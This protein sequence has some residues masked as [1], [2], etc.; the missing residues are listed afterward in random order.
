MKVLLT[1]PFYSYRGS[2]PNLPDIALGY[3]ASAVEDISMVKIIDWNN[4]Q[5]IET[6][7]REI[8]A[9]MPDI[10][11]IKC[12]TVN[13]RAVKMTVSLLKRL[14]PQAVIILG[15]PHPT[16]SIPSDIREEFPETDLVILGEAENI[17]RRI[18]LM[19]KEDR[20]KNLVA[21]LKG[22]PGTIAPEFGIMNDEINIIDNLNTLLMPRWDLLD[23]RTYR[24]S[25]VSRRFS[26][27]PLAPVMATRGCPTGCKFCSVERI[28][29]K[30]IRKREA[31][32][33]FNEMDLL[34]HKYGV[35]QFMFTDNSF[36]ADIE[37]VQRLSELIR[38]NS[39]EI[40]YNMI[41]GPGFTRLYSSRDM[42]SLRLSGLE[43]VVFGIESASN[44]VRKAFCM[45]PSIEE[46]S[47]SINKVVSAGIDVLGFFMI[48]FPREDMKDIK[49]TMDYSE[50]PFFDF[51]SWEI[52]SPYP[53]TGL[54]SQ[55]IKDRGIKKIDWTKFKRQ[56]ISLSKE[57][58]HS[59]NL[60]R[61]IR[62]KEIRCFL[63][64]NMFFNTRIIKLLIKYI[65]GF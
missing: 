21:D 42:N 63:K 44:P 2:H 3:L 28:S 14:V 35:R 53:G 7:S 41:A 46:I 18:V 64:K 58:N 60:F 5:S 40:G 37:T 25:P 56:N 15:G 17:F 4:R 30:T 57:N 27:F 39:M 51:V 31:E 24:S 1:V 38:K 55:Y 9:Y 6:L 49:K 20:L 52:V 54:Y 59:R 22:L 65:L 26:K 33:I 8:S 19:L 29:G 16:S 11:G 47:S 32:S 61:I 34:Y 62:K 48:G 36:S 12:F 43:S 13:Y 50:K 45:G 10:I 23:P